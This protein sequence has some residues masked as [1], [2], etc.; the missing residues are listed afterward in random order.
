MLAPAMYV[1]ATLTGSQ[2]SAD[3]TTVHAVPITIRIPDVRRER[4]F[5]LEAVRLTSP[6][7][8]SQLRILETLQLDKSTEISDGGRLS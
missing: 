7:I 5:P 6:V 2:R 1:V 3:E 8:E 4:S